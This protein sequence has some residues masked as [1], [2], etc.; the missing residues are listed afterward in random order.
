MLP[1]L[2]DACEDEHLQEGL[3]VGRERGAKYLHR[4]QDRD[5]HKVWPRRHM[6]NMRRGIMYAVRKSASQ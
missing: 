6:C 2:R 5:R 4:Q 3:L 1:H